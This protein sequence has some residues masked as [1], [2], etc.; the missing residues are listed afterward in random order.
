MRRSI[1]MAVTV[2]LLS[3]PVC[4][5]TTATGPPTLAELTTQAVNLDAALRRTRDAAARRRLLDELEKVKH[6][7]GPYDVKGKRIT[8]Q[9]MWH[10][11]ALA[12][13]EKEVKR[14]SRRPAG[15]KPKPMV[16]D[17]RLHVRRKAPFP[18]LRHVVLKPPRQL[19]QGAVI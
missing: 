9:A 6:Q 10:D 19:P 5:Q 17:A 12:S 14:L 13:V 8:C 16:A 11:T 7:M 15:S 18:L 3:V 2:A 1:L 4:A